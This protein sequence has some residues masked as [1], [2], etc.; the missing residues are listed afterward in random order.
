MSTN[1]EIT[2]K[3]TREVERAKKSVEEKKVVKRNMYENAL[4][5]FCSKRR[6]K[7]EAKTKLGTE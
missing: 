1:E 5:L 2:K 4:K 3:V 6:R 7:S